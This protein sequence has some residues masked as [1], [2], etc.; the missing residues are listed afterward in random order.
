MALPQLS[1]SACTVGADTVRAAHVGLSSSVHSQLAL[2]W[3]CTAIE[4]DLPL[5]VTLMGAAM[6]ADLVV[7]GGNHSEPLIG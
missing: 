6:M 5:L 3:S 4:P 2:V 1:S 7:A